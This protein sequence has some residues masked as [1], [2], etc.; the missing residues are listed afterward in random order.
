[1][2]ALPEGS[3][4]FDQDASHRTAVGV[5]HATLAPPGTVCVAELC[6]ATQ[7]KRLCITGFLFGSSMHLG[8]RKLIYLW[9]ESLEYHSV[10]VG[11]LGRWRVVW[12]DV[13]GIEHHLI[14]DLKK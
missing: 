9:K 3:R 12:E 6:I 11:L 10:V 5:L 8:E 7:N 4:F 13:F 14:S 1:M 2:A